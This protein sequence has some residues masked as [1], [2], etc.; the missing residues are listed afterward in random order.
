MSRP[1]IC[2]RCD[3]F[4]LEG[5]PAPGTG[6]CLGYGENNPEPFVR[7]DRKFCV[8]YRPAANMQKREQWIA[9]QRRAE[10]AATAC[11]NGPQARETVE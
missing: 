10:D 3:H 1:K 4:T 2:A 5:S 9:M 11:E 8:L 7:W 6:R